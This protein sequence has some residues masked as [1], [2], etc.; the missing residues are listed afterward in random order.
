M[1]TGGA[2]TCRS[3]GVKSDQDRASKLESLT[4]ITSR[5]QWLTDWPPLLN[6]D[7]EAS[8]SKSFI[9][10]LMPCRDAPRTAATHTAVSHTTVSR[11]VK[12]SFQPTQ[13]NGRNAAD[14]TQ[15]ETP[16]ARTRFK[17][18]TVSTRHADHVSSVGRPRST[19]SPP[20]K[21][22]KN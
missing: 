14:A 20:R 15:E 10:S 7:C 5:Q 6:V 21:R 18:H 4:Y 8:M 22:Q 9:H 2:M 17:V 12:H 3:V 1:S 13:H 11:K 19:R 16:H